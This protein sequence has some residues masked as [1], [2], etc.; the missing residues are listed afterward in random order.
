MYVCVTKFI[1]EGFKKDNDKHGFWLNLSFKIFFV[2][3][4][5][6]QGNLKHHGRHFSGINEE[7]KRVKRARIENPNYGMMFEAPTNQGLE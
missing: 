1:R 7:M 6:P 4:E 2:Q 3:Q 5:G